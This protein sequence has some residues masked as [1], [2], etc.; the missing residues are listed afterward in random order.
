MRKHKFASRCKVFAYLASRYESFDILPKDNHIVG[1]E[2]HPETP[3]S[4]YPVE[5]FK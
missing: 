2:N 5:A 1:S 3:V 4:M